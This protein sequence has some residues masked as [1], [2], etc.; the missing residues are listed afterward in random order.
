M[1][2]GDRVVATL[3][4]VM[5]ALL[6]VLSIAGSASSGNRSPAQWLMVSH[7][8]LQF[9]LAAAVWLRCRRARIPALLVLLMSFAYPAY[10][11][12]IVA[13]AESSPGGPGANPVAGLG[14]LIV[15]VPTIFS[16]IVFGL[17]AL[18]LFR[19]RIDSASKV[20]LIRTD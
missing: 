14:L 1:K 13:T 17:F 11:F 6:F 7:C 18:W 12:W 19:L 10:L 16:T 3:W 15:L 9:G 5:A 4:M 20:P 2:S 8:A